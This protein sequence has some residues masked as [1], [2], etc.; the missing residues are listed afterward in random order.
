MNKKP[1][2]SD[3]TGPKLERPIR[4]L[5]LANKA[6]G[7]APGQRYRFEQWAPRLERDFNIQI[8]LQPFE[9][10]ELTDL[11]YQPGHTV[12]KA[13]LVVRDFLRRSSCVR[14]ATN[15]DAVLI[16]REASLIGPAI[17]ERVI[18]RSGKPILFD[19][20]DSI[21][22]SAQEQNNGIF[23]RLHFFGKTRALCRLAAACTPGN[24]FLAQYAGQWN[25]NVFVVPSSIELDDYPVLPEASSDDPFTICWTGST[26]TLVNFEFA[27]E[28]L[29]RLAVQIPLIVKIIC[30]RPP[31]RPIAGADTQFIPWSAAREA[32]HVAACHVGIMP[33]PDTEVTRGKCGLKALQFMATGRP[34]VVSPVGVNCEIVN[35]GENGFLAATGQDWV[36]SLLALATSPKLRRKLGLAAR[37]TVEQN[38]SAEISAAKFAHAVRS[39]I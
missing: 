17:Y 2:V 36:D 9:S 32:E 15:F 34:V 4:L 27:R 5:A 22:S 35:S 14:A 38:Y 26:S 13:L 16:F 21:W 39:V 33:L 31:D 11:L 10:S 37:T 6:Q 3:E 24:S 7:I 12:R 28:A 19:F 20:D 23:S 8:E 1:S 30:S 29:E 18:A 25:A